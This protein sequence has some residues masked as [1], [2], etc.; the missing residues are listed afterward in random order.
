VG[1]GRYDG[2]VTLRRFRGTYL[3]RFGW[4]RP[5]LGGGIVRLFRVAAWQRLP[6]G[7]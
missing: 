5:A 2:L 4:S 1:P 6:N 3:A 7:V